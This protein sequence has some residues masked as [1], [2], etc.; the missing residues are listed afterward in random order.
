MQKSVLKLFFLIVVCFFLTATPLLLSQSASNPFEIKP[1]LKEL[2]VNSQKENKKTNLD[3]ISTG[4]IDTTENKEIPSLNQNLSS[5]E[6][7]SP[8]EVETKEQKEVNPFDVDHVPLRKLAASNSSVTTS[9]INDKERNNNF[10]FWYLLLATVLFAIVINT[11][12]KS[13]S[14]AG[15]SIINDNLLKLFMRE[16]EDRFSLSIFLLYIVFFINLSVFIYIL[17]HYKFNLEID[18]RFI[19][20]ILFVLGFYLTKHLLLAFLGFVYEIDKYTSIYS[21]TIMVT[22]IIIG[23]MLLPLNFVFTFSN[24]PF[25]NI[26]FI[27]SLV[28]IAAI[29]IIRVLRGIFIVSHQFFNYFFQ[30]II[31]LCAFEI[32]PMFVLAKFLM[33][34]QR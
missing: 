32:A 5:I 8:Q 7:G 22:N 28:F 34:L 1:R 3:Q 19:F 6:T 31:Y 27:F 18:L 10:L 30:I 2:T 29:L 9:T 33:N 12:Y 14:L 21:F 20:Y 11:N 23:I 4:I 25:K 24:E 13:L 17:A 26:A 16:Q 15:K